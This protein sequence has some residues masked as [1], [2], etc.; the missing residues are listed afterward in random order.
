MAIRANGEGASRHYL[1]GV[2]VIVARD[3]G[4]MVGAEGGTF[5]PARI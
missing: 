2:S 1:V 4:P 3:A 5:D